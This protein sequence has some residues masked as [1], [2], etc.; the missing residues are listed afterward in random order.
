MLDW[1]YGVFVDAQFNL[2]VAD[3][4]NDRVQRFGFQQSNGTT[5]AGNGTPNTIVLDCPT[6]II[7]DADG[8]YFISENYNK[9]LIASG[10]TGFRCIIGCASTSGSSMQYFT[11]PQSLSFDSQGNIFVTDWNHGLVLKFILATNSCSKYLRKKHQAEKVMVEFFTVIQYSSV[12]NSDER[13]WF[14]V[15]CE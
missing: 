1:P 11:S 5:I 9:R 10:P 2:Y 6:G 13:L 4:S 3:C 12:K 7:L 15:L 8:Y 14:C